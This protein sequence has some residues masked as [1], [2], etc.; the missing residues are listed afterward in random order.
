MTK[1][2]LFKRIN[3]ALFDMQSSTYQTFEQHFQTF[4]LLISDP[5]LLSLNQQLTAGLDIEKFIEDSYKTQGGM[6]GSARLV[7]PEGTNKVLGLQWLLIQWLAQEPGRIVDFAIT[8]YTVGRNITRELHSLTRQLLIPFSRDYTEFVAGLEKQDEDQKN[9]HVQPPSQYVTYNL[10]GSNARINN[11]SNDNS[12]NIVSSKDV[13]NYIQKLRDEIEKSKISTGQKADA[14]EVIGEIEI[15][16]ASTNPKKTVLR[17]LLASLPTIQSITT[18]G[19]N[20]YDL[21]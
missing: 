2:F 20:L 1:E 14:A 21:L 10:N 4:A 11:H 18:I 19:K 9:T 12:V 17:A 15:Q 13:S 5:S 8:F 16:M 6:H 3:N 7:W